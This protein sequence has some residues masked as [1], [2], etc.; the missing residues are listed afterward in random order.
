MDKFIVGTKDKKE[1]KLKTSLI[2][3]QIERTFKRF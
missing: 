3:E 2:S 1:V